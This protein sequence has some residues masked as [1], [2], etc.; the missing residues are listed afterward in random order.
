[1]LEF[2]SFLTEARFSKGNIRKVVKLLVRLFEKKLKTRLYQWGGEGYMIPVRRGVGFL[3]IY[4][5]KGR[6]N[7][8]FRLNYV[9]GEIASITIW[10]KFMADTVGDFTIDLA[11]L[12]IVQAVNKILPIIVNPKPGV[13][14]MF[15]DLVE[16]VESS[17]E[18]MLTEA[19]RVS[20]AE[21]VAAIVPHM[22]A[23]ETPEKM[24]WERIQALA[25]L[26]DVNI[27]VIIRKSGKVSG[28]GQKAVFDITLSHLSPAEKAATAKES[29]IQYYV[30]VTPQ[31]KNTKKFLS[32]KDDAV[33][34]QMTKK[35]AD[36]LQNPSQA[37]IE[38]EIE[39]PN[40][41]F[42]KMSD[43][44]EMAARKQI[45]GLLI[46]GGAG[47]GKS[48]TVKKTLTNMGLQQDRQW[49]KY[50]GSMS[51][52]Q[53]YR[54]LFMRKN[55][56]LIVFDDLDSMWKDPEAVNLLKAAMDDDDRTVSW[57]KNNT[58][59]LG[60]MSKKEKKEFI[61]KTYD[62]LMANPSEADSIKLPSE[63]TFNGR[64]IFISNL[65]ES[66]FDSAILSRGGHIDMTL[67]PEQMLMRIEYL[68]PEMDNPDIP[69]MSIEQKREVFNA[70]K[71]A[72]IK[73]KLTFEL[74][75]RSFNKAMAAYASGKPNWF[76]LVPYLA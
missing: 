69:K 18:T 50:K 63:F 52:T 76:E 71:S 7:R 73:G 9:E 21:F 17:A 19:R 68:L 25:V 48:F 66:K 8:A 51:T 32:V 41:L 61:E 46:Y 65:P 27:P 37:I 54:L 14:P 60:A 2:Q 20:P 70:I 44:V 57:I 74:T 33:A 24:R 42:G 36:L 15:E 43:L 39:D 64:I 59:N 34:Q 55:G 45:S 56:G 6:S 49:H 23:G 75:L 10:R 47:T 31:D 62:D 4:D 40:T 13:Y 53:L 30:K 26:A 38:K 16:G 3:F 12:N 22:M 5:Y 11:G 67:T 35:I 28:K 29:D 58:V 72:F 1:M